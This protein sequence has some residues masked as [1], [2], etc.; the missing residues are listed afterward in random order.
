L[1]AGNLAGDGGFVPWDRQGREALDAIDRALASDAAGPA[2]KRRGVLLIHRAIALNQADVLDEAL[3]DVTEGNCLLEGAHDEYLMSVGHGTA[4]TVH[5]RLGDVA[6]ALA[7]RDAEIALLDRIGNDRHS[8]GAEAHRSVLLS[9]LGR[10][11]ESRKAA[12]RARTHASRTGDKALI[13]SI[14]ERLAGG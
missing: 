6:A 10:D 5:E 3:R 8:A 4:A 12:K 9:R 2:G 14:D 7:A 13:Q 11:D 1:E